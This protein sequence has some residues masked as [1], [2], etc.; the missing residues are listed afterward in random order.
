M[1]TSLKINNAILRER[2]KDDTNL[3]G[4]DLGM[5]NNLVVAIDFDGTIS[6]EPHMGKEL[7]LQPYCKEVLTGLREKGVKFILWTCR[8][9]KHLDEAVKFL[10]ENEMFHIFTTVNNQLP[11][12]EELYHPDVARKVGADFYYDDRNIG[13]EINWLQFK[14]Q[15]LNELEA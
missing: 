13:T 12:I 15:I 7:K 11:E 4:T 3:E 14:K 8:T 6:T 2:N 10:A 9:G 1:N 5:L